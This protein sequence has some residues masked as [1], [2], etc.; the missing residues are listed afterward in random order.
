MCKYL[1]MA[2]PA[3]R[4]SVSCNAFTEDQIHKLENL[5]FH[6]KSLFLYK[7]KQLHRAAILVGTGTNGEGQVS[8]VFKQCSTSENCPAEEDIC[9]WSVDCVHSKWPL[10]WSDFLVKTVREE[11]VWTSSSPQTV[12]PTR[13]VTLCVCVNN[14]DTDMFLVGNSPLDHKLMCIWHLAPRGK[15]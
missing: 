11:N 8:Y 13:I 14:N 6:W 4:C 7:T 2:L 12:V 9:P 15:C 5:S 1:N 3:S 10:Q